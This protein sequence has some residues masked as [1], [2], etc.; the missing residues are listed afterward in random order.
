MASTCH[1][2]DESACGDVS[3]SVRDGER[4][5]LRGRRERGEG[6]VEFEVIANYKVGQESLFFLFPRK[7]TR[8]GKKIQL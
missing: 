2:F 3:G 5:V 4:G 8:P 6:K 1:G 7:R